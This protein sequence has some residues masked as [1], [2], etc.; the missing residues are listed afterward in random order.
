LL[1]Y[2]NKRIFYEKV[3]QFQ[4]PYTQNP[5]YVKNEF[6]AHV[7]HNSIPL[8]EHL[9]NLPNFSAS[10]KQYYKDHLEWSR[11]AYKQAVDIAKSECILYEFDFSGV[12]ALTGLAEAHILISEY[13]VRTLNYK[14]AKYKE[15]DKQRKIQ[16]ILEKKK[17]NQLSAD[18]NLMEEQI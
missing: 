16:R 17:E 6:V 18:D 2:A 13:R 5:K 1:G 15:L 14:Y 12:D 11:K 7:P 10:L 3:E 4:D 9:L 8:G